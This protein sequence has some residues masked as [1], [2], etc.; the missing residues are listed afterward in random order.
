MILSSRLRLLFLLLPS[1]YLYFSTGTHRYCHLQV[2]LMKMKLSK[3]S[4][5]LVWTK[6]ICIEQE[7]LREQFKAH[8]KMQ[9]RRRSWEHVR[10]QGILSY[11]SL[12]GRKDANTASLA[13]L[14]L[15]IQ[16]TAHISET[17]FGRIGTIQ[18][19]LPCGDMI[20]SQIAVWK[21][22]QRLPVHLQ[23]YST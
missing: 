10:A 9:F 7:Y 13:S 8:G 4:W 23:A 14:N 17:G 20:L 16:F 18:V 12:E 22:S 15:L 11:I 5:E 6:T 3:H 2:S 1:H 19:L 21:K